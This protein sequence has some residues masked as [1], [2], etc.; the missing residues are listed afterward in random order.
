MIK[1]EL[2][3]IVVTELEANGLTV[4]FVEAGVYNVF[5]DNVYVGE[6]L[7]GKSKCEFRF[8]DEEYYGYINEA[9]Y[10]KCELFTH[11]FG[12]EDILKNYLEITLKKVKEEADK[13][14]ASDEKSK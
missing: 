2:T 4:N 6:L 10:D 9:L 7:T 1:N 13:T 8:N 14:K 11:G 12:D 5:K 3:E